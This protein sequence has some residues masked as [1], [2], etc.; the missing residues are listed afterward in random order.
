MAKVNPQQID[1]RF[2]LTSA[3]QR[4]IHL[5]CYLCPPV[6]MRSVPT[7]GLHVHFPVIRSSFSLSLPFSGF[8]RHNSQLFSFSFLDSDTTRK[9]M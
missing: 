4:P 2:S 7:P 8:Y 5:G 1:Y 9:V 3:V 6:F